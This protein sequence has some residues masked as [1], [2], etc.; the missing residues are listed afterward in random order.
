MRAYGA[1]LADALAAAP[2]RERV[3]T[4]AVEVRYGH[5]LT[6]PVLR[7]IREHGGRELEYAYGT[8]VSCR[9]ALP[10]S[11]LAAFERVLRDATRGAVEATVSES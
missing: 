3:R 5:E 9:F 2:T 11:Q 7:A 1:A 6:A 4:V 8:G 10:A